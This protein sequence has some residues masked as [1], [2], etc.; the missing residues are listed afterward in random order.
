MITRI[1][2]IKGIIGIRI[3]LWR[4]IKRITHV[5]CMC[6]LEKQIEL[7]RI[8]VC[9]IYVCASG[10]YIVVVLYI[11]FVILNVYYY[12]LLVSHSLCIYVCDVLCFIYLCQIISILRLFVC[13]P[14]VIIYC[15]S[16]I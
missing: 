1:M 4:I 14:L 13:S 7:Y 5:C 15:V 16:V 9:F 3:N 12:S 6:M 10:Y 11:C 2:I 8:C